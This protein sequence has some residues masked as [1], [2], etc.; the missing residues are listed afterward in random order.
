MS[1]NHESTYL[2][3][4]GI[5]IALIVVGRLLSKGAP[6]ESSFI[7]ARCSAVSPHTSRTIEAWRNNKTTFFCQA[8]HEK[9]LKTRPSRE[10]NNRVQQDQSQK[11]GCLGVVVLFIVVP[12]AAYLVG[13]IYA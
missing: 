11:S 3:V 5:V 12:C 13:Q 6:K 2:L 9:W 7:C 1:F 10:S 8:C 4:I